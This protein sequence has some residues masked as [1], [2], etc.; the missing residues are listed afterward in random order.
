M[1]TGA[2]GGIGKAI[3]ARLRHDGA[4]VVGTD[5]EGC[6]ING[7]LM[8]G[9]FCDALPAKASALLGGLDI[10]VNNAGIITRGDITVQRLC[11][12]NFPLAL[13]DIG[14]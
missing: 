4:T 13:G 10:V 11:C 12:R 3:V 8:D 5:R 6:E 9:A 14:Q 7:D 1:V 2:N